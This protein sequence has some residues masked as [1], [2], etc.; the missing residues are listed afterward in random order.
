MEIY[1]YT[2]PSFTISFKEAGVLTDYE[3]IV[4]SLKQDGVAQI[5]KND[6]EVDLENETITVVFTQEDTGKLDGGS[7]EEPTTANLQVNIYYEDEDRNCTSIQTLDVIDNLY[8]G[9]IDND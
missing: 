8:Q 1:T 5:D 9:V 6:L 3:K 7:P 4:V 2:T